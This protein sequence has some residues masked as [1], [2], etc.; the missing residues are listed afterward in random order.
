MYMFSIAVYCIIINY[1][2]VEVVHTVEVKIKVS[3]SVVSTFTII[4]Y[5]GN[6]FDGF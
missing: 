4:T 3:K 2:F 6:K 5:K 1:F